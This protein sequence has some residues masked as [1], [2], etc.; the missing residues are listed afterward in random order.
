MSTIKFTVWGNP[1][2]QKRHRT[3]R[4]F[5]YDPSESD[6]GDFKAQALEHKPDEPIRTAVELHLVFM[7]PFQ[8]GWI[9]KDGNIPVKYICMPRTKRPDL[10]NLLKFVMDALNGVYWID[11]AVIAKVT[12]E[13]TYSIKPGIRLK[14]IY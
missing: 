3:G 7:Y 13:K 10:D 2:A 11:D 14:I 12:M 9:K 8:K 4:G 5:N 6:K 1:K